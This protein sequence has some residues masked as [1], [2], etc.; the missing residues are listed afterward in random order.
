VHKFSGNQ[1]VLA[2]S[3]MSNKVTLLFG[4]LN[5]DIT[6]LVFILFIT[7]ELLFFLYIKCLFGCMYQCCYTL[8]VFT[9][10]I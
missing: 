6:Q 3:V 2:I 8:G 10:I 7:Y 9:F 1:Y 4:I 5:T